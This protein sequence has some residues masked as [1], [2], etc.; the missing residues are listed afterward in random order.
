MGVKCLGAVRVVDDDVFSKSAVITD[1]IGDNYGAGGGGV[2]RRSGRIGDVNAVLH[3]LRRQMRAR[4]VGDIKR[5]TVRRSQAEVLVQLA[6]M[7]AGT[8]LREATTGERFH[9]PIRERFL[10]WRYKNENPPS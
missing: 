6:D 8:I 5:L 2:N 3:E 10:V 9:A 4:Q 1:G 7:C